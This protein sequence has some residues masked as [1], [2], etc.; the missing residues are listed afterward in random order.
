MPATV[1]LT[2][3]LSSWAVHISESSSRNTTVP[4]A[5]SW[6]VCERRRPDE[7]E[8][9]QD[10][11]GSTATQTIPGYARVRVATV[12]GGGRRTRSAAG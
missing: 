9:E 11:G 5:G 3:A 4:C 1:A 2:I 12:E 10:A 8:R 7:H 6:L